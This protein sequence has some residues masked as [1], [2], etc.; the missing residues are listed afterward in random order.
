MARILLVEDDTPLR[1]GLAAS[2]KAL[3]HAVD[4]APDGKT[5][6]EFARDHAYALIILDIGLPDVSGFDVLRDLR[7]GGSRTP[8]LILTARDTV[9]D[10]VAG[11]DLGA[12]DYLLKPFA[13]AELEARVR[14]LVRR[15]Q[16]EPSPLLVVG[17]LTLD[18]GAGVASVNGRGLD[19]RRREW[20]VLESLAVRSGKVVPRERLL[21]DV[22]DYE[23]EI[24]PNALEVYIGRL[25]RKL[26]PDGP[27]IRTLRGLGYLLDA[28][29]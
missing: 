24:A 17:S 2:L 26:E 8:I 6:V 7:R 16:G 14:A 20:A 25:R 29:A 13:P 18:R 9:D 4:A 27:S 1:R 11:L 12:D 28:S 21:A 23:D 22:F 15:G 10:R 19:L 5:A 3:G